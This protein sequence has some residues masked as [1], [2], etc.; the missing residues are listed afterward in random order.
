MSEPITN[1]SKKRGKKKKK[2][3]E[4]EREGKG[5]REGIWRTSYK[6]IVAI[7]YMF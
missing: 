7:S 2:K 5:E 1:E 6:Q 3:G 4:G